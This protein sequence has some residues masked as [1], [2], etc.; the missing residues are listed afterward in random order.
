MF[1][2]S[3]RV[4]LAAAAIG[5]LLHP[6]LC[7]SWEVSIDQRTGLP[8]L[9]HGG[10]SALSSQFVF[11]SHNWAWAGLSAHVDVVAPYVYAM[12]SEDKALNFTL[13]GVVK[14]STPRQLSWKFDLN[15]RAS[16]SDV[17][18]GGMSFRFDP[19]AMNSELG[20]PELLPDNRGWSWGKQG[21]TRIEMRFDPP[22]EAVYFERGQKSE[23][24]AFFYRGRVEEGERHYAVSV[25]ISPD[26]LV[27]P[28]VGERFGLGEAKSWPLDAPDWRKSP[29]DVSFLNASEKPAGKH[30]FLRA[31]ADKLSFEDGTP[32]RFWGTNVAAY[33]LFNTPR[34][35][36]RV[37][38]HRLAALGF[39]LV[40]I[41][42][43][44]LDWVSPN[45]FGAKTASD[46]LKLSDEALD[47]LDW[48]I[49]SLEEEGIYVWLDL[50]VGRKLKPADGI[51][52]FDEMSKG[53]PSA[54]LKGFNY[55]NDS[56]VRAMQRF[57]EEYLNHRNKYTGLAYKD[58]P[59]V[60]VLLVTNENDLTNHFGNR[61][62]PDKNV[63]QHDAAYMASASAFALQTGL[64]KDKVWRSWEQGVSKIF[65]NDLEHR[66]DAAM[67]EHL[68]NMGAKMPIVTT[69]S[70]GSDPASSLP[71]LLS[72]D[73][74]DVHTYGEVDELRR[75][76]LFAPTFLDW[77]AAAHVIGRPLAISE[78]N[79]SPFPAPDRHLTP[80]YVAAVANH[81]DWSAPIQFAYSQQI[82]YCGRP[83]NWDAYNDPA[84]MATMP[85]AALLFRRGD[86]REATKTYVLDP[87]ADALFQK[88]MSP[89]TSLAIRMATER[90]KLEIAM[91]EVSGLPWLEKSK[92]P[93]GAIVLND[94]SL[95][96]ERTPDKLVQSDT[97]ELTRDSDKG[98]YTI[99]TP[100]TQAAMGWIGG[101]DIR[102]RDVSVRL[103]TP[104]ATVAV[105]SLDGKDIASSR[106][107]M[108][109][110]A[111]E[112]IPD[113]AAHDVFRSQPPKGHISVRAI[114][115]LRRIVI[116]RDKSADQAAPVRYQDGRYEMDLKGD[117]ALHWI[118]LNQD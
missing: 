60:A 89:T 72:G 57:N 26:M 107:I 53:K 47:Q 45:I 33:A 15:A 70:W 80:L 19:N 88:A 71:A 8:V 42:H 74:V 108:L 115:N 30:G 96:P 86:V 114:P 25:D 50:E 91:P 109:T 105:Q 111:G 94:A 22:L 68:R 55:V 97:G 75:N 103:E 4:A 54:D 79:V 17:I 32:V 5:S 82:C 9:S 52:W 90:S 7:A 51:D 6:A 101:E 24:R 98:I 65:L 78:W 37:Q 14:R 102:L 84:L 61:L 27:V 56:I 20:Q 44:D 117:Q 58:D 77:A 46:T 3:L 16:M 31:N 113:A 11:W 116:S 34:E 62:L 48:W 39:N 63:P 85:A 87:G 106:S 2:K 12:S 104:N 43:H 35:E 1:V 118:I 49:K 67:I 83:S 92:I 76:P 66:F 69:S 40:R 18:G 95:W 112:S 99:D 59:G 100:R 93:Q 41:H 38:A 73:I 81:Q 36:V 29:I 10:S 110:L 23:I 64:P 21:G 13:D 28:T